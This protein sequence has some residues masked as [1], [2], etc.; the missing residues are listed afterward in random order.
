MWF[1]GDQRPLEDCCVSARRERVRRLWSRSE[2]TFL[3]YM[4][5]DLVKEKAP[6]RIVEVHQT[7]FGVYQ[8][9]DPFWGIYECFECDRCRRELHT[10]SL[11]NMM[12]TAID[13]MTRRLYEIVDGEQ[14]DDLRFRS[15]TEGQKH[16]ARAAL[17]TIVFRTE[18]PLKDRLEDVPRKLPYW[19]LTEAMT[20]AFV[21]ALV[22]ETSH[23]GPQASNAYDPSRYVPAALHGAARMNLELKPKQALAWAKELSADLNA[24]LIMHTDQLARI[25]PQHQIAWSRTLAMGVVFAVKAWDLILQEYTFA[26]AALSRR[27][28]RT[29]PPAWWRIEH[30]AGRIQQF[31][32]MHPRDGGD[33]EWAIRLVGTLGQLYGTGEDNHG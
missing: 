14:P 23:Q 32:Q 10:L 1:Y 16:A 20:L 25:D 30:I 33:V 22:H 24:Y 6:S 18:A 29:H 5:Y 9:E 4:M 11:D 28:V 15:P 3:T 27:L 2:P 19:Y 8:A 31:Q 7:L 17:R 26:N 13:D 21:F 12:L